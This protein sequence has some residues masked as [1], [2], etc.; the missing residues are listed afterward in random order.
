MMHIKSDKELIF[1]QSQV[2]KKVDGLCHG[3][4]G[5][6]GGCSSGKFDSLN[7]SF[8]VGDSDLNVEQNRAFILNEF[9]MD[10]I[11]AVD[12]VHGLNSYIYE[13]SSIDKTADIIMTNTKGKLLLIK[14]ADCQPVLIADPV[15]KACAAVHSGW[16]GSV[17]N[18]IG[19]AVDKM[20]K[21]YKSEREDLLASVGPSLGPCC[22]EFVNYKK[23][24]PEKYRDFM[25][26]EYHFDFWGISR[27]QLVESGL[28]PLNI[29]VEESCT[30]CGSKDYFSYRKNRETGRQGAVIGWKI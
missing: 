30:K 16:K 5:R 8:D 27:Y 2:L 12:Q 4:F 20:C 17:L 7:I 3:F 28:S 6:K 15:K 26:G 13:E 25:V 1:S 22:G 9:S 10:E 14:T 19:E 11:V 29:W 21:I 18:V 24:I 23:E